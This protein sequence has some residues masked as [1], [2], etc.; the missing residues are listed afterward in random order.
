MPKNTCVGVADPKEIRGA[1]AMVRISFS[2]HHDGRPLLNAKEFEKLAKL[3]WTYIESGQ[4]LSTA[5]VRLWVQGD[6]LH[7]SSNI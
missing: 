1:R 5:A 4:L 2:L 7:V 3:L 6:T